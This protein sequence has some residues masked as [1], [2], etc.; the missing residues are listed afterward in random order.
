MAKIKLRQF[1]SASGAP[2]RQL[3][4]LQALGFRRNNQVIEV[5]ATPQILGMFNKLK[6]LVKIEE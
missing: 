2:K 1:K 6:H 5:E 4:T 3:D